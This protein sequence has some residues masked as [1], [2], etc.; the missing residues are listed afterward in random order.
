MD[1]QVCLCAHGCQKSYF[2]DFFS[3]VDTILLFQRRSI[4]LP[5][6]SPSRPGCRTLSPSHGLPIFTFPWLRLKV[7]IISL[8][9][10]VQ[11]NWTSNLSAWACRRSSIVLF[12]FYSFP[13]L[14]INHFQSPIS[15]YFRNFFDYIK[16]I[17][18]TTKNDLKKM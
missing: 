11:E 12:C 9:G 16:L 13:P 8:P 7:H 14:L 18:Q 5:W 15:F 4:L 17:K 2:F 6:E 10:F 3:S 1:V